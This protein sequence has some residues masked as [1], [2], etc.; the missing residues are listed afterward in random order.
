MEELIAYYKEYKEKKNALT[1]AMN[2]MSFDK[3]TIAP[4]DGH[5]YINKMLT[6]LATDLFIHET[7]DEAYVNIK[8]LSNCDIDPEL[9]RDV[10]LT[11]LLLEENRS[12][13]KDVYRKFV[14]TVNQADTSWHDAKE[15]SDYTLFENDLKNVIEMQ[16]E[17]LKYHPNKEMKPY[18]ILLDRFER[19]MNQKRYDE[20]FDLIKEKLLPFIQKVLNSNK[21]IDDSLLLQ[22]Y[23]V[24]KQEKF[25][26]ELCT[27]LQV[28]K[29]KVYLCTTEHPFTSFFSTNDVRIT[30]K[31]HENA[32]ASAIYST[33]HEYGHALYGLQVNPKYDGTELHNQISFAM[34]ESQSRFLENYIGKSKAFWDANLPSLQKQFSEFE[35][36]SA[37]ELIEMLSKSKKSL[38]RI[39]ADEL[40]Y[41]IHILIR[42]ELEKEIFS[43][44]FNQYDKLKEKWDAKYKEYLGVIPS[45]DSESILQDIHWS[46]SAFGYFPTY[47]LGSAYSAQ[48]FNAMKN[49]VDIDKALISGQFDSISKWL[50][51]NIHQYGAY[52]TADEVM[53]LATKEEFNANYYIEYLIEKYSKLYNC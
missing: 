2:T 13:P 4:K 52:K 37:N 9:K 35:G 45:N 27:Y 31:F 11:L 28:D 42:Y 16:K 51:E 17:V 1:L 10:E 20:F 18:D 5:Q 40:T 30:T 29:N 7:S 23:S 39:E 19:G 15:K 50:K 12:I 25:I 22:N 6:M 8:E 24:D 48:F 44:E 34:H 14:Q 33:I 47:A 21:E 49:E 53:M 41:P 26:D 38:I 32:L 46:G 36:I 43:E 3:A